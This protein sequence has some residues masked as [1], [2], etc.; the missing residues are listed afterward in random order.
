MNNNNSTVIVIF[1]TKPWMVSPLPFDPYLAM[2]ITTPDGT[3]FVDEIHVSTD[4]FLAARGQA[5][6]TMYE[7]WVRG[8]LKIYEL[9]VECDK[10][11]GADL[12]FTRESPSMRGGG[13]GTGKFYF[14]PSLNIS[15]GL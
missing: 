12:M 4:Q 2:A 3:T 11:F 9:H 15:V 13:E 14:D 5:N 10:G 1:F 8:D 6:V 7:N